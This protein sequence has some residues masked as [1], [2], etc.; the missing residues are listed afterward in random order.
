MA[1]IEY[2]GSTGRKLYD[3]ADPNKR[4]AAL[5]YEGVGTASQRPITQ[6]A[7]F[8]TR[9]NRGQSQYHGVTLGLESRK[10]GNTRRAVHGEVHATRQAKDNL[11]S[12]FSDSAANYNLGY[13]DAFDPML[14]YGYAE[15][16]IR[17]RVIFA[18]IWELPLFRNSEGAAKT[19]LGGW[20]LNWIFT[21]RSGRPFSLW[22]CTNGLGYCMRAEDPVGIDKNATN[23]PATGNPNEFQLIDLS[24]IVPYAG[25]Y[26][27]PITGNSDFG[28]YPA[29]MTERNAFRGPGAWFFDLSLVQALPLRRPLRRA[30]AL[31]G[32][33]R[34]Q[35][36]EHVR[37]R[38]ERRHQQ[39]LGDHRLQ[40][41]LLAGWRGRR[42]PAPHPDRRE[43][44][45]LIRTT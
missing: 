27:N 1:S 8:N 3:L 40:G 2:T 28:P 21:A 38:R 10:L 31:R 4:G 9:G 19:L 45:V 25:G 23:G 17:H 30:A 6:Y 41:L 26:V 5:V 44:R 24:P 43:V 36:R 32:V 7:A 11:S 39:L 42:R 22:D 16:D 33:Q 37:G 15:F 34:V 20:Q 14:D 13:L 29:D 12:T 18:G 35:P